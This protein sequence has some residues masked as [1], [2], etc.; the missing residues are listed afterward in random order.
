MSN[1]YDEND[2]WLFFSLQMTD[3][4]FSLVYSSCYYF[5]FLLMTQNVEEHNWEGI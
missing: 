5:I 4:A 2:V 1:V 3:V